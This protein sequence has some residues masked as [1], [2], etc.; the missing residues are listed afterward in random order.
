MN[1]KVLLAVFKR[2]FVSYFANPTG[3][4]F[5][6]LFVLLSSFA[7]F[8]PNEFFNTNLAN[9]NQLSTY[10]PFIMLVFIPAITMSI[11]AD[12]RRQG[13]DELLLTIPASDFD[14]VLGKYLA[15]VAIFTV[16]LLFSFVCNLWVLGTLGSPDLG[17][18]TGTYIGYWLVGLA[19]LA[20]GMVASFL[21]GNLTVAFILGALFN[22]PLVYMVWLEMPLK[23][24]SFG[25]QFAVFGRG[26]L[27]FSHLLYFATI[28]AA[29]LYLS[30]VFIGRRHWRAGASSLPQYAFY[31]VQVTALIVIGANLCLLTGRSNAR[32]LRLDVTSERLSSLSND[33]VKLLK[34]LKIDQPVQIEAFISPEVPELYVQTHLDLLNMLQELKAA[35]GKNVVLRINRTERFSDESARAEKRYGIRERRVFSRNRG[36]M[37][38]DFIYMGVAFTCGLEKVTLPF[39]D[40][41]I[42]VEY[43]LVRSISTVTQQTRKRIGVLQTDAQLY[44]QFNMQSMSSTPNWPI[45]GELEKQYEVVRVDATSPITERYDALLAV[46]PS[47]LGPAQWD[48]FIAAIRAGQP[49]AI[50]EDPFPIFAASVPATLAPRRAPGGMNPMMMQ[51][52]QPPEK[53]NPQQ[54][55]AL[56]SMLGVDFVPNEIIWQKY[57]P[58][59]A[60]SHFPE[61][62]VFIDEGAGKDLQPFAGADSGPGAEISA[63][64]QHMLFP[65][66]GAIS[67]LNASKMEFTALARTGENTGTVDFNEV[68]QMN[69]FGQPGGINPRRRQIPRN[70]S[71]IMAAHVSGKLAA[72]QPPTPEGEEEAAPKQ[73]QVNVVLVADIDLL[74]PD[75]FRLREQGSMPEAGVMFDFDNVTFVLNVLDQ[76]A[77]DDRF[78]EIRKRRSKHR[79]LTK[80]ELKTEA[81]RKETAKAREEIQEDADK[82]NEELQQAMEDE[83]EKLQEKL[84]KQ[85]NVNL[86]AVL[87]Q[88]ATVQKT[89]QQRVDREKERLKRQQE[90][91]RQRIDGDLAREIDKVQDGYKLRAVLLPPI[92]PLMLA[93]LVFFIRRYK[94]R[95]G[96]S[97]GRLRS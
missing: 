51:R 26:I 63:G 39:V 17:L 70:M 88:V 48:N 58:Y 91:D 75:F 45:I 71:Y 82:V 76:L 50:F 6:C 3:Y 72:E 80:V 14:V 94:E 60:A 37:A 53:T 67:P 46:Q 47:S 10:F 31:F 29:M 66:P 44:G 73:S 54:L 81:A 27:S 79:T 24:W 22:A 43:E 34:N 52:Q 64:L 19:M 74:S 68:M 40:R 84:Q 2:N 25:E 78:I 61:E 5:I 33:T 9:L 18:F 35:G 87:T 41:G 97:R 83:M 77:N 86:Q 32:I 28:V 15:A 1:A 89:R 95:E 90:E 20:V 21:T 30:I 92:P 7:A 23:Q 96:V 85:D 59:K 65:F 36:T 8:W 62:F 93:V 12:E 55:A 38:E 16:S 4:V 69:M 11:W 49:T 42:P 13:T 56:W 57:N